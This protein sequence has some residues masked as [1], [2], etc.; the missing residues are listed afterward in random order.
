MSWVIFKYN[1][2]SEENTLKLSFTKDVK[3]GVLAGVL[4]TIITSFSIF[5]FSKNTSSNKTNP[6]MGKEVVQ[7]VYKFDFP[8]LSDKFVL[9]KTVKIFEEEHPELSVNYI[10]TGPDELNTKKKT[11]M[12]L[13]IFTEPKD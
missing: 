3:V 13:Y 5:S 1:A 12:L 11:H 2:L 4:L 9:E 6:V 10:Y 7:G 8:F